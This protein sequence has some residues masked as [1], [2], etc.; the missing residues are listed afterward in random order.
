MSTHKEIEKFSKELFNNPE[1]KCPECQHAEQFHYLEDDDLICCFCENKYGRV[2][3]CN[4]Y[5]G[6]I[7]RYGGN[8]NE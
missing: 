5:S 3:I 6:S 8:S 2:Y 1:R 4:G 7:E